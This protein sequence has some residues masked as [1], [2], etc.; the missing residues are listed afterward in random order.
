MTFRTTRTFRTARTFSRQLGPSG[1]PE[2]PETVEPPEPSGP[3]E[4]SEPSEPSPHFRPEE[5]T[6][7]RTQEECWL[8]I[9]TF[10]FVLLH[11]FPPCGKSNLLPDLYQMTNQGTN[12]IRASRPHPHGHVIVMI[13][14]WCQRVTLLLRLSQ[15]DQ[16]RNQ[17]PP[18]RS[19]IPPQSVHQSDYQFICQSICQSI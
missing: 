15:F 10:C 8:E 1:P 13:D 9:Q 19:Q 16:E 3:S 14:S 18:A 2:Q 7:A 5:N 17:T 12:H 6:H 4:P 11:D